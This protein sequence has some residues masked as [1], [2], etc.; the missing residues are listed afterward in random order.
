[1]AIFF[2]VPVELSRMTRILTFVFISLFIGLHSHSRAQVIMHCASDE[3]NDHV[4]FSKSV[5]G[6]NSLSPTNPSV[7]KFGGNTSVL[8][9][10]IITIP[11]VVHVLYNMAAENV[12]DAQID[13]QIAA[14]NR[15]FRKQ[16]SDTTSIPAPFKSMAGDAEI[17]F[18]LAQRDPFG[19]ATIGITRT[20][21]SETTFTTDN[22][23][24][25]TAQGGKDAWSRDQYLNIWVGNLGSSLGGY[26]QYP[27]GSPSSDG[28]VINYIVF[29]MAP[30][31]GSP[32]EKG[33][34]G[35]HEVGHWLNLRHPWGTS[36]CGDD[37]VA[38]TPQQEG[39]N[40]FCP[41]YPKVSTCAGNGANGDMYMNYMDYTFDACRTMFSAGQVQRMIALFAVLGA[42]SPLLVSN[43]CTPP[44]GALCTDP[45]GLGATAITTTSASL[46]WNSTSAVSYNVRYRA[47]GT[48]TWTTASATAN[49]KNI[50]G[51]SAGTTYDWQ[52]Q[53][54]CSGNSSNYTATSN[55]TTQAVCV[56]PAGLSATAITTTGATLNWNSTG[57]VSYNV[58]YRATGTTPWT[59]TTATANTK[60]ISGLS[61]G[62]AYEWQV[63]GVCSGNSSNYSTVDT[64]S[65]L[66]SCNV[67]AQPGTN[68]IT[69]TTAELSW[70]ST[71]A[72]SYYV[73][74]R[75]AGSSNWL[76]LT[77]VSANVSISN[78]EPGR[79]YEWQ[80][81]STC[82]GSS[83]GYCVLQNFNTLV[84]CQTPT[85]LSSGQTGSSWANISWN[86]QSAT[87]YW[88][89]YRH[90]SNTTW[91]SIASSANSLL[92]ENLSSS[93]QYEWMLKANCGVYSSAN[94]G[95]KIFTTM[96][97]CEAPIGTSLHS[98]VNNTAII[99]WE[100][101]NAGMYQ[102][103]YKKTSESQYQFIIIADTSTSIN[104]LEL[105]AIYEASVRTICGFD[106][107]A[108]SAIIQFNTI[109]SSAL[110][111]IGEII[112]TIYPNP[113]SEKITVSFNSSFTE[114]SSILISDLSG[115]IFKS[116]PVETGATFV[117]LEMG[118]FSA[119]VYFL[120][121]QSASGIR[122]HK[123][124]KVR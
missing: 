22:K 23:I 30:Y 76:N 6:T 39:A 54:V 59:T 120:A 106:S 67:P 13:S 111:S 40:Y 115:R 66:A 83:S 119:G 81:K 8:S 70:Q 24:K 32:Y 45:S 102:V 15:D 19:N 90:L 21:T 34:V 110:E 86:N 1:M 98:V 107:S 103:R 105:N 80:V 43:G 48:T 17:E 27:G 11:V 74:F 79:T 18:C 88:V 26:A 35:V 37:Y 38:D 95:I 73:R 12:S 64:F 84:A 123:I 57:A 28:V 4:S 122:W 96:P 10:T 49:T 20:F 114:H 82:Q 9:N 14:L 124:S 101:N 97:P 85:G 63:Q 5:N 3:Y 78:L 91:D 121:V 93:S 2:S 75:L 58:R 36:T 89:Y 29:G 62:T 71:N 50:S 47:T 116:I 65:T 53:G 94:S 109:S 41:T 33:R 117:I 72:V 42:R 68:N 92:L 55:F 7:S 25:Y 56:D 112:K 51:L 118:S 61:A 31:V 113:F 44:G 52:V 87:S 16:N 60:N 46:N 99:K 108:Y 69:A 104:N 100:G 77:P